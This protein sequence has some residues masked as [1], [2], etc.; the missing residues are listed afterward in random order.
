MIAGPEV[1][2]LVA[3]YESA[4]EAKDADENTRH[5]EQ[6]EHTQKAVFDKVQKLYTVMKDMGNP[7]MDETGDLFT[8][9]TKCIAHPSVAEMIS[10]HYDNGKTRFNEFMKG[11]DRGV[12]ILST[13]Q[14]EQDIFLSPTARPNAGDSKEKS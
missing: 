14:E 11:L 12:F 8:L 1:S 4:S 7:F 13:N 2:H 6:T 5:H 3:Q 10:S 9:D